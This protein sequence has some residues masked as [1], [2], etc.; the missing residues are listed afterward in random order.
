MHDL[1]LFGR[2]IGDLSIDL[3][4]LAIDL[5][6]FSHIG[7]DPRFDV[8]VEGIEDA[9]AIADPLIHFFE[10]AEGVF[11]VLEDFLEFDELF[12]VLKQNLA[13]GD[14]LLTKDGSVDWSSERER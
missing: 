12:D 1:S 3:F 8:N 10:K 2:G 7:K 11:S 6:D 13:K 14:V 9:E 5:F 4:D